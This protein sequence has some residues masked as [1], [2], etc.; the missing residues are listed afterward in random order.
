VTEPRKPAWWPT[1]EQKLH[2]D[3]G[4][5]HPD[6]CRVEQQEHA[7]RI[8]ADYG[9][10]LADQDT[11]RPMTAVPCITQ[12]PADSSPTEQGDR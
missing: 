10:E 5:A 11:A 3:A 6:L 8:G 7:A 1:A 2:A 12:P 9:R 4:C